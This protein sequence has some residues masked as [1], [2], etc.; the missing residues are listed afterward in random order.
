MSSRT[1]FWLRIVG[2]G[3]ILVLEFGPRLWSGSAL[4]STARPVVTAMT[5]A[6]AA[7]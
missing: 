5:A 6:N 4:P 2:V 3:V 7:R 1:H